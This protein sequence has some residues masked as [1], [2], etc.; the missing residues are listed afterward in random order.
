L[1]NFLK[2]VIY[3]QISSGKQDAPMKKISNTLGVLEIL[4]GIVS[5]IFSIFPSTHITLVARGFN[6]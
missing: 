1:K 3:E 2:R 5:K 6:G 4:I